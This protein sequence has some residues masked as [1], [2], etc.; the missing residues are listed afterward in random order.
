MNFCLSVFNGKI[1][2]KILAKKAE[3]GVI[4]QFNIQ[5]CASKSISR[6]YMPQICGVAKKS[7]TF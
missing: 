4:T 7:K 2:L 5:S 3:L 1:F 6:L